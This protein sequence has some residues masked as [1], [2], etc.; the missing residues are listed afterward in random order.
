MSPQGEENKGVE[1]TGVPGT[2]GGGRGALEGSDF[3]VVKIGLVAVGRIK[4]PRR[5]DRRQGHPRIF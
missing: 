1:L 5:K 2:A 3:Q 4:G